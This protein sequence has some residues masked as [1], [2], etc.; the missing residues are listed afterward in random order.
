M[1][2]LAAAL[3]FACAPRA[4]AEFGPKPGKTTLDP[5]VLMIDEDKYLGA[6]VIADYALV[7]SKG[8]ALNLKDF[9]GKPLILVLSYYDCEGACPTLNRELSKMLESLKRTRAGEDYRVLTLSFDKE[10]T[11]SKM[12]HFASMLGLSDGLGKGWTVARFK[13][14]GDIKKFTDSVGYRFYWSTRERL[15]IHPSAYI[16]ASPE[17]RITRVLYGAYSGAKDMELAVLEAKSGKETGSKFRDISDMITVGCYSYNYSSGK[18]TLNYPLI[19]SAASLF[20]GVSLVIGA[21][22]LKKRGNKEEGI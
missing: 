13:D 8:A 17:G 1:S 15:F 9:L 11:D 10:D 6:N 20:F 12:T 14:N 2:V 22:L 4:W 7:D 16:V 21:L 19:I 5:G 18:Y 3:F